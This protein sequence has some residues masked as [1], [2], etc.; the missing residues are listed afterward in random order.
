MSWNVYKC[1]H[2]QQTLSLLAWRFPSGHLLLPPINLK[3]SIK[4][5]E[6]ISY[7]WKKRR[8]VV[9]VLLMANRKRKSY[10]AIFK[11]VYWTDDMGFVVEG[12]FY[13]SSVVIIQTY[14]EFYFY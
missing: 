13:E 4:R 5:S 3:I 9:L 8:N 6:R 10:E 11:N 14:L 12:S 1:C 2:W 7:F